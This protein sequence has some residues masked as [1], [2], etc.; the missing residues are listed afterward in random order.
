MANMSYCRF[1]NTASDLRDVYNSWS[2][3]EDS[4]LSYEE[5]LGK[6]DIL[7]IMKS[8]ALDYGLSDSEYFDEE[9]E[10]LTELIT[11]KRETR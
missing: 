3:V 11:K 5:L 4:E 2:D 6:R 1:Q 9:I 8:F 10:A 7:R